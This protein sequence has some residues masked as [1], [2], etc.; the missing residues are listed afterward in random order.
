MIIN[1][2]S[3]TKIKEGKYKVVATEG[4]FYIRENGIAPGAY[5][6]DTKPVTF[7]GQQVKM[8]TSIEPVEKKAETPAAS[9]GSPAAAPAASSSSAKSKASTSDNMSKGDWAKKDREMN[10]CGVMK[11]VLESPGLAMLAATKSEEDVAALYGKVFKKMMS[12]FDEVQ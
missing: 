10:K 7:E 1:V 4:E 2:I 6:I 9:I 12:T 3:T 11:S 5:D 8:I